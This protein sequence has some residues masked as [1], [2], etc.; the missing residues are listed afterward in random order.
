MKTTAPRPTREEVLTAFRRD[1]LLGA[2]RRVFGGRGFDEATMEA[3]AAEAQ[4]AKGTVYLYFPSKLAIY[5]A[6]F[7]AG[8]EELTRLTDARVRAASVVRDAIRAFVETR[9]A[10][11]QEHPDYFRM[12]VGEVS[13]Q[14][15]DRTPRK[16]SCRDA[17]LAHTRMLRDA[18]ARAIAA[19]EMRAVDPAAA[20]LAVFD[21]TRGLV[22]RRLL[23]R[24]PSDAAQEIAFL[25][26]L[27]WTG[28]GPGP[29]A[30]GPTA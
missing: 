22:A 3:I 6:A 12:Y 28:L 8:M 16:S 18:F 14:L 13:R 24:S 20:A 1:A 5:E 25:T 30:P 10:Y 4:V 2:A 21:I 23:S 15:T 26:D 7:A 27:I 17:M 11:F 29:D 19:G 9:V